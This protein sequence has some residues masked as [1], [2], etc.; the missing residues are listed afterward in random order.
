MKRV[1]FALLRGVGLSLLGFT[2]IYVV[3]QPVLPSGFI[4]QK[5]AE[6]IQPPDLRQDEQ[7]VIRFDLS[8]K[9]GGVYNLVLQR[10]GV[11]VV[12]GENT[13]RVDLILF[14]EATDFN[15]LMISLARGKADE[16]TFRRLIISKVMR[17]AGDMGVFELLSRN[18][19]A[20]G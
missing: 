5:M 15:D 9:G 8:G 1:V 4:I 10:D 16:F 12:Q 6:S 19:K 18:G 11:K 17:F 14:M 7:R 2:L 20:G 13:D 3:W